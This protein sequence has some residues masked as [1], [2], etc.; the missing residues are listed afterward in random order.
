MSTR[1]VIRGRGG[2]AQDERTDQATLSTERL[3]LV[4]LADEHLEYEVELDADPEVMRYLAHSPGSREMTERP[5]ATASRRRAACPGWGCGPDADIM[6]VNEAS[7]A[8]MTSVGLRYVRALH[9]D[10][11]PSRLG[12]HHGDVEYAITREQWLA[13]R[14]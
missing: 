10:R 8:T 1:C 6:T 9:R 7:R 12:A 4:P 2:S 3:R 13:E 5:T 11:D 14:A